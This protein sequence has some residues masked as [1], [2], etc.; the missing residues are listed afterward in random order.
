MGEPPPG[1]R[2]TTDQGCRGGAF[3]I[4]AVVVGDPIG[5]VIPLLML[6]QPCIGLHWHIL[7]GVK[8]EKM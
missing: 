8:M 1:L 6:P 4:E 2:R 3:G 5:S 7:H